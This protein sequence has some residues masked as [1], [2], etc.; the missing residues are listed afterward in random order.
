MHS[1]QYI[2]AGKT[3][4]NTFKIPSNKEN[5]NINVHQPDLIY[6]GKTETIEVKVTN[7]KGEPVENVDLT[8]Y[9][10]T[11]KFGYNMPDI[12]DLNQ[13]AKNK[14]KINNFRLTSKSPTQDKEQLN[15]GRS[16]KCYMSIR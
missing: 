1:V 8:A 14:S 16:E 2:W 13:R 4:T 7:V 9:A 11:K 6:P 3:N 5:L 15:I 12:P 10:M